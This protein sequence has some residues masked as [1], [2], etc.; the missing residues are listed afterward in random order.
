MLSQLKK[1]QVAIDFLISYAIALL[2]VGIA[3]EVAYQVGILNP[4][5][6]PIS[7]AASPGFS[8]GF[9]FINSTGVLTVTIAQNIGGP[10]TI[11]GAACDTVYNATAD[12][13][14]YGNKFVT[15]NSVY[16]PPSWDPSGTTMYSSSN[17][18]FKMQCY[19]GGGKASGSIGTLYFGHIWLNFTVPGYKTITE[20]VA[21][22]TAKYQ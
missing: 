5:L 9:M 21:T 11:N 1:S 3:I 13:P 2:I 8:C 17:M 7:C 22:I 16:Y 20:S 14:Q 6:T 18:T 10:I 4:I 19:N 12:L 15:S